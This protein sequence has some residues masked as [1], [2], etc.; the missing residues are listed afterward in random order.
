MS[1]GLLWQNNR[2]FSLRHFKDLGLGKSFIEDTIIYEVNALLDVF[3]KHLDAPYEVSWSINIAI[4][5]IIWGLT[6]CK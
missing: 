4:S 6:A 1:D 2:R 3:D 5:N